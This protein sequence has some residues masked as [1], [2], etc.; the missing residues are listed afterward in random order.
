VLS[1][2]SFRHVRSFI[3]NKFVIIAIISLPGDAFRRASAR[4]KTSILVLKPRKDGEKQLDVFMRS[5]ISLGLEEKIA[6]RIGLRC[7][8]L[9]QHKISE[10]Q[11]I[12]AA[13]REYKSGITN[14]NVV[15]VNRLMDRLDVKFCIGDGGRKVPKWK[16]QGLNV[17]VVGAAL[18]VQRGRDV[19][20]VASDGYQFLRVN[21]S[22]DIIE[23]EFIDGSECSYSK[24]YFVKEW[25]ILL[26]NMGVGR[27]AVG[28][29]PPY[30]A[31]KFVSNE[32]TIVRAKTKEEAVYY[33]TL[34]RTKEI[35]GDILAN[36]TGMNRGRIQ[37][38]D[39]SSVTV[40]K[41]SK[42]N[43]DIENLVVGVEGLWKA[44]AEFAESKAAHVKG[45]VSELGVDA[46]D[47][48]E[49]W[50]AFKPPE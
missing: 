49:R 47:S 18:E 13:Y 48:H 30:H 33:S 50:L 21:Y 19:A 12:L 35:L 17:T 38:E 15:P 24:L 37:W 32:Y 44:H 42:P 22:G 7:P 36:T 23:G 2:Q 6:R 46:E 20:V 1:G 28:L 25:D 9:S 45:V 39:I 27:G 14:S 8:D 34:L 40:P 3:R 43:A 10:I 26:S 16:S 41:Y 29:V 5:S 31:G 11:D 4:V